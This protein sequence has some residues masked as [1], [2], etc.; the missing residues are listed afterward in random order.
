MKNQKALKIGVVGASGR[1]GH[2]LAKILIHNEQ[3]VPYLGIDSKSINFGY[4]H[5]QKAFTNKKIENVDVWIDFSSPASLESLLTTAIRLEQPVVC[6]T[7]GLQKKQMDLIK[8]ASKKIPVL[9]SSNMSIGV[10]ILA[11]A[12]EALKNQEAYDYQIE[13]FHH[14][15]K[16]DNPSGTALTL[17]KKL[18][19]EVGRSLPKP[20]GI[21]GGGIY[22]IHKVWAMGAEEVLCFEH[23][24]LNRA[25]FARG[26]VRAAMWLKNQKPGLYSIADV[27]D[28]TE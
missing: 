8:K 27:L 2:E 20:I 25:V 24:A 5:A 18:E 1:M 9:W 12:L 21:R 4:E 17:H 6:G 28:M 22:G 7:T 11:R 10:A 26:A 16:K 13:E 3:T 23:Q 15:A 14:S 19:A